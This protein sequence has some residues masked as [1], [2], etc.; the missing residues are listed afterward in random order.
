M[1]L[2]QRQPFV[3][4]PPLEV[5]DALGR[6]VRQLAQ[7]FFKLL[8]SRVALWKFRRKIVVIAHRRDDHRRIILVLPPTGSELKF[9]SAFSSMSLA[10]RIPII[11]SIVPAR[12]HSHRYMDEQDRRTVIRSRVLALGT[13]VAGLCYIVWLFYRVNPHHPWM[14]GAFVSAEIICLLLFVTASFTVWRLRYKPEEGLPISD[15]ASVDV[16][17]TVCGEPVEMVAETLAAAAALDWPRPYTVYVL[18]DGGS[19]ELE[20]EALGRGFIY[21]SR[22]RAGVSMAGAK[23]G[24]LNFG[25]AQSTGDFILV[26]D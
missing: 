13:L 11:R 16:F 14:A 10:A 3:L 1:K 24:N 9:F 12:A 2:P 6:R 26:L 15:P 5:S 20:A 25:L 17:V 7:S 21:R 8:D 18:D 4:E 19:T 23:A 22:R